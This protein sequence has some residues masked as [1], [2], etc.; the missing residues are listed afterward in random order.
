MCVPVKANPV[1]LWSKA[2]VIQ[3]TVVWHTAQFAA[4]NCEPAVECTGLFV[5]SQVG[6]WQPEF[7]QSVGAIFKV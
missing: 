5:A 1:A 7:P 6:K 2:A 3:F 4:A